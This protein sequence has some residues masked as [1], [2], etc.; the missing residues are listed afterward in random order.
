AW[1]GDR[2]DHAR[3]EVVRRE[4]RLDA[5]VRHSADVIAVVNRAGRIL[6]VS[7]AVEEVF[8]WSAEALVGS[9]ASTTFAA[10]DLPSAV[11]VL[12]EV[13]ADPG[14]VRRHELRVIDANGSERWVEAR[15]ANLLDEPAVGG[16]VVNLVDI[17]ARREMT[18]RLRYFA[19]TDP[20][21]TLP[22]RTAFREHLDA[23][24]GRADAHGTTMA[25]LF[26]DLDDFKVVN[27]SLGHEAGDTVLGAV[28][29]Q[30]RAAIPSD[31]MLARLGGDEFT[32]VMEGVA[33]PTDVEAFAQTLLTTLMAPVEVMGLRVV[34]GCSI[35]IAINHG[36]VTS[37][38]ELLRQA[39]L[40]MYLAKGQ[41]PNRY[42]VFGAAAVPGA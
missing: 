22:N 36:G 23:A 2:L 17:S 13:V 10:G 31:H 8:G 5:L 19:Y 42:T 34:V 28:A 37:P 24:A 11:A 41:G 9:P 35:G 16:V 12:A 29:A 15:I 30:L 3:E 6:Y 20:I 40:A 33:A 21:T 27:D 38:G 7:P 26:L 1:M 25:L 4:K 14:R 18:E 32:V 39:D